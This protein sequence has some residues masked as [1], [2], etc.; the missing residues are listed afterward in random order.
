M[1]KNIKCPFNSQNQL[2]SLTDHFGLFRLDCGGRT[3]HQ[4]LQTVTALISTATLM[5]TGAVSLVVLL[6]L[7]IYTACCVVFYSTICL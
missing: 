5:P 6:P 4:D 1:Y 2:I 7:H 3:G